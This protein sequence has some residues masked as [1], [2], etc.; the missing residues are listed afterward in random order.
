MSP[1]ALNFTRQD[2]VTATY[3]ELNFVSIHI[4]DLNHQMHILFLRKK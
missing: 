2:M 1:V 4:Y 3:T